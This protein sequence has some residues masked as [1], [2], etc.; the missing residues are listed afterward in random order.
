VLKKKERERKEPKEESECVDHRYQLNFFIL[1]RF[2]SLNSEFLVILAVKWP[3]WWTDE[4]FY[5]TSFDI[6]NQTP[7]C[8]NNSADSFYFRK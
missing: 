4:I 2:G 8:G 5:K 7:I 1:W 6:L 3:G